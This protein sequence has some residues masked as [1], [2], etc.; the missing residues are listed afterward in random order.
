MTAGLCALLSRGDAELA[1][2]KQLVNFQSGDALCEYGL[3]RGSLLLRVTTY[4]DVTQATQAMESLKARMVANAKLYPRVSEETG[5]GERAILAL[6]QEEGRTDTLW[7]VYMQAGGKV[8]DL[9]AYNTGDPGLEEGTRA[10]ARS[11]AGRA[12]ALVTAAA[13]PAASTPTTAAATSAPTTAAQPS[14]TSPPAPA[15]GVPIANA[16]AARD[17]LLAASASGAWPAAGD[18]LNISLYPGWSA[19]VPGLKLTGYANT[20]DASRV[21]V[22]RNRL[23]SKA[24][25][26]A[27]NPEVVA[28]AV[29]DA[30]GNCAGGAVMGYPAFTT[31]KPVAIS[32]ACNAQSVLNTLK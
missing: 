16:A 24:A 11:V 18:P 29:K 14:P 2:G 22:Y 25:P 31:F 1:L 5:I 26:S 32:G 3:G 12:Q 17:A 30:A 21:S 28:F 20:A 8:F 23:N 4:R 15:A 7:V 19:S 13:T 10:I 9:S 27:T 6:Y